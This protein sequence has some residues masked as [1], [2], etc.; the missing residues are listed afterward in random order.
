[1]LPEPETGD[2]SGQREAGGEGALQAGDQTGRPH[3]GPGAEAGQADHGDSD[4]GDPDQEEAHA[5]DQGLGQHAMDF[6][7]FHI[8]GLACGGDSDAVCT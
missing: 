5:G 3:Q 6:L 4:A 2:K 1:M 8:S 7:S